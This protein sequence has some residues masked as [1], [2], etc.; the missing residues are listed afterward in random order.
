MIKHW[1]TFILSAVLIARALPVFASNYDAYKAYIKGVLEFRAGLF[2]A[3]KKDYEKAASLD[4]DALGVYKDLA[5]LYWQL[6]SREKAYSTADK[7]YQS[8]P[9]NVQTLIF[10]ATFYLAANDSAQAKKYWEQILSIEPE[11]ETATVYLAAYYYSGNRLKESVE[12]WNKFL[13][14]QPDSFSGYLQLGMA[15]EKLSLFDEAL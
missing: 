15:Q 6:G 9:K 12:Y 10:L 7:I 4:A 14:Q 5:Y 3:A 11:N 2:E 13:K 1:L 8:D